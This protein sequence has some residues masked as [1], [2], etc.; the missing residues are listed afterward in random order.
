MKENKY[1]ILKKVMPI[2]NKITML[3]YSLGLIHRSLGVLY[4]NNT[5]VTI[6]NIPTREVADHKINNRALHK[7]GK[8]KDAVPFT[9]DR[10]ET[11]AFS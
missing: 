2:P 8:R 5:Y 11:I 4:I 3:I 6:K 1:C 9:L 7:A 10:S